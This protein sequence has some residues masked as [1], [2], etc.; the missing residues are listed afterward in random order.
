MPKPIINNRI[1]SHNMYGRIIQHDLYLNQSVMSTDSP[2]F[3]NVHLTGDATIE[4]NLYVEGNTTLLETNVIAFEDNIIVVNNQETGP[5]VTLHQSGLEVDRGTY[6]NFRIVYNELNSRLEAGVVSKLEPVALRESDP[7]LDGIMTWNN[8]TKL[9]ESSNDIIIPITFSN[10]SNSTSSTT[11]T[12]I[13]NGGVGIKKDVFIDGKIYLTGNSSTLFTNTAGNLNITS[14]QDINITPTQKVNIPFNKSLAFGTNTISA[15]STTSALNVTSNGDINLTPNFGKKINV[16][17]QIPITFSTQFEQIYTDSSN[18]IVVA[19]SQDVYLYPNNGNAAGKKVFIPVSTNLA[20]GNNTQTI[21]ANISNDLNINANNNITLTPGNRLDVKIPIDA[22]VRFGSGFQ[23]ITANSSN[24]L[25]IFSVGDLYLS[26]TA[27]SKINIPANVPITFS[28]S[29]QNIQGDT[30]GNI[31][32]NTNNQ[33]IVNNPISITNTVNALNSTTGTIHTNGGIG[34]A[35]DI[36]GEGSVI[37]H[38][39]NSNILDIQNIYN[40]SMLKVNANVTTGNVSIYAGNGLNSNASLDIQSNNGV[41]AQSL[42]QLKADFDTTAAYMIGR[43]TSTYNNGRALTINLPNYSDYSNVGVRSKFSIMSSNCTAELFSIESETGNIY[44]VGTLGVGNTRDSDSPTTGSLVIQGGLGVTKSIYTSGKYVS[45]VDSTTAFQIK[46]GLGETLFNNDT[47]SKVVS[48]NENVNISIQNT[49]AFKVTDTFNI[50]TINKEL[51]TNLKLKLTNTSE[52]TDT[53]NGALILNGGISIQKSLNVGGSASF[54]LGANMLNNKITNLSDPTTPQDAATK[55]YV[56]LVKQG[57]YVKDS[58]AV[59]S[60][61]I[62]N[63]NTDLIVGNTI[64]NYT[65]NLGDRVLVKNQTNAIQNGIYMVTPSS[66]VRAIDLP[67]GMNASGIFVFV[68]SGDINASLGWIC[69]S[70]IGSDIIGTNNINFT[71]FTGLGQVQTK[72]GLS[73]NFNEIN[74]NVD[75]SSLE[76]ET[77][78]NA[79]RIKS[80]AL[81][82]GLTGGSGTVIQTISDQSHVTKL[83]TLN[84][85]VWQASTVQVSYGGTGQTIFTSGN[86]LFGNGTNGLNTQNTFFYDS[87]NKRLG[88]GTNIPSKD[89][90]IQS[91]NI[92]TL[93]LKSN[94][95]PEIQLSY[96]GNDSFIGMTRNYDEYANNVYTDALVSST[97]NIIQLATSNESRITIL[98]NGNVGINTSN[99]N[100]TLDVNGNLFVSSTKSSSSITEG[101]V[102]IAGGLSISSGENSSDVDNGGALTVAGG[103]SIKGDLYIGGAINC[104]G[105]SATTF[106]YLTI[107]ATDEAINLTSG[108]LLT[109]GGITLQC[110][111]D[112]TSTTNGGSLLT[113]GGASIGK[114]LYVGG[115]L[116][117]ENDTYL[118]NMYF[119]STQ[120]DNFISSPNNLRD[121]NSFL[122]IHF[123]LNGNVSSKIITFATQGIII[124]GQGSIQIGGNLNNND[125]YL[126]NY[127]NSNLNITPKTQG[128]F[129]INI[130]TVGNYS[131]V[132]LYGNAGGKIIWQA[133]TS[134]LQFTKTV[135]ELKSENVASNLTILTP[136]LN[137]ET[138]IKAN[139]TDSILNIGQSGNSQLT[140]KLS[141]KSGDSSITFTPGST[142][143]TLV[144][145]ENVGVTFNGNTLFDNKVEFSGNALHQTINNTSGNSEW[146]YFGQVTDYCEIDVNGNSCGLKLVV[147]VNNTTCNVSHSHYGDLTFCPIG[148]YIYNDTINDY[149]L[150][151]KVPANSMSNI[152][153]VIQKGLPFNL[154]SEG[155]NIEPNGNVSNYTNI[156]TETYVT[157]TTS[158]LKYNVGDLIINGANLQ[159]ADNFPIIGINSINSRDIGLLYQRYQI[160]NDNGLGDI[161][162]D[163][164]SAHFIDSIPSQSFIIDLHQVRLSS[165]ASS[166]SNYYNG[167]WLKVASGSNVNQVRKIISYDGAQKIATLETPFTTQLPSAGTTINFYKNSYVSNYYDESSD[168]FTFAYTNTKPNNSFSNTDYVNLRVRGIESM[169]T[170]VSTNSSTGSVVLHGGLS[171][172]NTTNAQSST[173]G[174][175]LTSLGGVSIRK[176]LRVGDNI[177]VGTSGFGIEESIHIRKS[178]V[179]TRLEHDLNSYSYIDFV[180][181]SSNNRYGILFDSDINQ[182][183]LTNTSNNDIPKNSNIALSVNNSG[184]IGINT[185]VNVTS[186]LAINNSNFISTNATVGYLGL[187]GGASNTNDST[188]SSRMLLYANGGGGGGGGKLNLYA[189]NVESGDVSIFTANDIE[190]LRVEHNGRVTVYS[191]EVSNS[192]TNGSLVVSG[193]MSVKC[194]QNAS[195]LTSG[196]AVT[197]EGGVAIVKDLHIGGSIYITGGVTSSESIASPVID[198]ISVNNCTFIEYFNS[199]LTRNNN[200]GSLSFAFSVTPSSAS[201]NCE[202]IFNV[203]NRTTGFLRRFDIISCCSG[204][205]DDTEMIPI[206]NILGFGILEETQFK[207]KFQSV[208]TG[209]HVIQVMCKYFML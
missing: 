199:A 3:A 93:L 202:I 95:K 57:L 156:W 208:S 5:G 118:G 54:S 154:T 159:I 58:V 141:N 206:M 149:H 46:N 56:D 4:G 23:R 176:D 103:A 79:L 137:S 16:P 192:A 127:L 184:Y 132:S 158:T 186:P 177:G 204:Y 174:G 155:Y 191:T 209:L 171:I 106:S 193:G 128:S 187:I 148:C 40:Q 188:V 87:T 110:S 99:P 6:E 195:S 189:G 17:N 196:G 75:D 180:E 112:A 37:L 15:N 10:T 131:N 185:T 172:N 39:N 181:N 12:V 125:G 143:S 120:T 139:G 173:N 1:N 183:C 82:T 48:I 114:S 64:D 60:V 167:W 50:D 102:V 146:V 25:T 164:S 178:V 91:N 38:S 165:L 69:N 153:V 67:V 100:S 74:V 29:L 147:S 18:N 68:K 42:I 152:N 85:G 76:I 207:I 28:T 31:K 111:T 115:S 19:S 9:I 138:F 81:G 7:L 51:N 198:V 163:S 179:G 140:T 33:L 194:T 22:G 136:D 96:L 44:S 61:S 70:A 27:G 53:S 78:S 66:P 168:K 142:M 160:A 104:I 65:L 108:S 122:P 77:I 90:D 94:V 161:V 83:G 126:L 151:V 32:I 107:T 109:F 36:Y 134:N 49:S 41:N 119:S 21:N 26:P 105:A 2:T 80:S 59:A 86:I 62:L 35:K 133:T 84:T 92:V 144:L 129:N 8:S 88:L 13:V 63:L 97:P 14:V 55:A 175:T 123:T 205:T 201:E 52:S 116:Y 169:D 145:T 72:N 166:S 130:G 34:V 20:F 162:D 47:I 101:S 135:I 24:D 157:D 190:R 170:I 124:N 43:G 89:L 71:E 150:F 98:Q 11:G 121:L 30:A 182:L 197:I 117:V 200:Y 73:K 113:P 45:S 203:P